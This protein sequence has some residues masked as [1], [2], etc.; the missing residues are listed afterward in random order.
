MA[1]EFEVSGE[2]L[3]LAEPTPE[4][5]KRRLSVVWLMPL[6]ALV[7]A[8]VV[9]WGN[10]S[11][12]GPLITIVFQ[13]ASGISAGSTELRVRDLRVGV[14]EKVGFSDGMGAIEAKLRLDKSIAQFVDADAQFWLVEPRVSARGVS[15]IGTLL[16]GVYIAGNWDGESGA[17][18]EYFEAL[19]NPPLVGPGEEGTRIVLRTRAGGQLSAGAPVLASGIEV[20]RIGQPLLSESGTT[21]TMD[22]FVKAPYDKRLTVNARFWNASGIS[23]NVGASGLALKVDS[24]AA[25]LEGGVSFGTPV[26]GGKPVAEGHVY[27]VFTTE[28]AARSDAFESDVAPDLPV[29]IVL[30]GDVEGLGI[31]SIVRQRGAKVGEVVDVV[32]VA[33][34]D[35]ETNAVK[36]RIDMDISPTRLGMRK[37]MSVEEMQDILAQRVSRGLRARVASEGLFG[38]TAIVELVTLPDATAGE[39]SLNQFGRVTLPAAP[40]AIADENSGVNGLIKR[41]SNLPFEALLTNATQALAGVASVT[42][43]AEDVLRSDGVAQVPKSLELTLAE[44]RGLAEDIR[45]GGA[46]QNLNETLRTA[47]GALKSIDGAAKTLPGLAKRLN[48]AADGLQAVVNGYSPQSRVYKDLRGVLRELAS[49]AESFRSLART[50]ERDPS[51]VLRGR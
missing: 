24:L 12:R 47:N 29:S 23:V 42:S 31:G 14:V 15:G 49:T 30:D 51:S 11:S 3:N 1:D 39:I 38:Q 10:Y 45:K 40:A 6:L 34:D 36:L 32:G 26:T 22:A 19:P 43:A 41:V 27:D 20:G 25:L 16:S 46:I 28:A 17:P 13:S 33:G 48:S 37:D 35:S 18:A 2:R 21:V 9:V 7:V 4:K 5:R 8:G 50:I 44:I